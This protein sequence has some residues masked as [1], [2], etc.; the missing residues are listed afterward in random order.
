MPTL[1]VDSRSSAQV[2]DSIAELIRGFRKDRALS[3]ALISARLLV[4]IVLNHIFAAAAGSA[5]NRIL[6]LELLETLAM[7]DARVAHLAGAFDWGVPLGNIPNYL[8]TVPRLS[9]LEQIQQSI[10]VTDTTTEPARVVLVGQTGNGKSVLASDHCHVDAV[11]YEFICWIDC[12][13]VGFVEEQVRNYVGQLSNEAVAPTAAVGSVFA[14]LLAR[15]PGPWLLV[16]DGIQNR[17]DIDQYVPTRGHGAILVTSN[18]SLN[19]WPTADVIGVGEFTEREA[20]DCFVSY[21][22][23]A[24]DA[25]EVLLEPISDMVNRLGRIPLAI[26]MSGIYF[27]NAEGK[28]SELAAQYFS[29]LAALADTYSIPPGFH[30]TAFAAIQHAVRSLGKGTPAADTYGRRA[31]A[32][33]EIGSLLAPELLPLNLILPATAESVVTNLATCPSQLKSIQHYVAECSARFVP[34]PSRSE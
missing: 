15:H 10:A 21:A 8:S 1:V 20:I 3:P 11:S 32:V 14:G 29:D 25:A 6:A 33:I 19:W 16:F 30:Q 27:K 22:G 26:S 12:R 28:L 4:S 31:R 13:D 24:A 23:I 17:S 18:N 5:P 9:Y 2:R 7:P 34:R